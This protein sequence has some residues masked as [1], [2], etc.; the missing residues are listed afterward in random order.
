MKLSDKTQKYLSII[1]LGVSGGSIYLI[2]FIKYVFYDQQIAAMSMTNA[3]SGFLLS[4]YGIGNMILYIPGGILADKLSPRKCLLFSLL[5][6][7]ALTIVYGFTMNYKIA[8]VIWFL[9]SFTT[10]LVFW[11]SL[12]KAVR[13]IGSEKE[14]GTMFGIYYAVNGLTGVGFNTLALWVSGWSKT[15][16]GVMFNVV[17][18]Y[19]LAT[20]V[21][22]LLVFLFLKKDENVKVEIS[23]DEKFHFKDVGHLIKNPYV[24]LFA[25]VVFCGYSLF[26]STSYFTPYLTDVVG[27]S[28][29]N[30]GVYSIIRNYLFM[31]LSPISGYI[32]DKVFKSTSKWLTITLSVLVVLFLGVL[33]IPTSA[34]ATMVSIYTLLPGAFGLASYSIVFSLINETK[35]PAKVTGTVI[36]LASVIGYSP[37]LFMSVMFGN[38]LD[39]L[40]NKGYTLIFL[41]LAGTCVVAIVCAFLIRRHAIKISELVKDT[42]GV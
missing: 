19:A 16:K 14:Q 31:L 40:K 13:M 5:S 7:T 26:S 27:V 38:W 9:F 20:A 2:P 35:I 4:M 15:T 12:L 6:T 33:L 1:T 23:E 22:A 34:N 25:V 39:R 41:Y 3:Q 8:L 17:M 21:A 29:T 37:D 24:W 11:A 18:V 30:S 42:E 10:V 36:G 32:A 28:P